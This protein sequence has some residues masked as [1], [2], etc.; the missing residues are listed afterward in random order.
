MKVAVLTYIY[1]PE[2]EDDYCLEPELMD[3]QELQLGFRELVYLMRDYPV[4]SS[5]PASGSIFEWLTAYPETDYATGG[6]L[7]MSLHFDPS[8][9]PRLARYWGKAMRTAKIAGMR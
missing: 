6:E 3:E 9:P 8:N 2:G 5:R 4:P 1:A 7:I